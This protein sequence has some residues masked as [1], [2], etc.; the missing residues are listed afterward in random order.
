LK[1]IGDQNWE[2]ARRLFQCVAAASRPLRVEELAEFLAF[3]FDAGS[4]PMFLADWRPKDPGQAVLSTCSSLLAV[5]NVD[6]LPIIQFAH[7][8]VKEYLTSER[9]ANTNDTSISRFHVSMTP[10]HTIVARGCLGVLLH[11]DDKDTTRDSLGKFPLLKYAA[12]H[13]LG[14][15]QFESVSPHTEEGVKRL[16]DPRKHHLAIWVWVYDPEDP[17]DRSQCAE[18]SP[19]ARATPLH[20]AA[21]C[22]MHDLVKFLIIEHSQ[23]VNTRGFDRNETPLGVACGKGHLEV[24]CILLEHGADTETRDDRECSPLDRASQDGHIELIGVLLKHGANVN[25]EDENGYTALHVAS[26]HGHPAVAQALIEYSAGMDVQNNEGE[27]P[28][29]LAAANGH[30][31]VVRVLLKHGADTN[32]RN[33]K[34]K[35]PL[36]RAWSKRHLHIVSFLMQ[37]SSNTYEQDHKGGASIQSAAAIGRHE[38]KQRPVEHDAEGQSVGLLWTLAR[39]VGGQLS[40]W[41]PRA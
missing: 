19:R 12:E 9:L 4:T 1:D 5:V 26:F 24:S 30:L 10:A 23:G 41:Y 22:G 8:S 39:W 15:A 38:D 29:H 25:F 34:G 32:L 31:E 17:E 13:W 27:T 16:F 14:H 20:Y 21:L 33:A 40:S 36:H 3:D 35:T 28:L 2:F 18:F 7:F 11:L 6:G 37:R